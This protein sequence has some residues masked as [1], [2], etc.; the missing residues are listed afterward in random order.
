MVRFRTQ[1]VTS[2]A[3]LATRIAIAFATQSRINWHG[4][5]VAARDGVVT[6]QGEVPTVADRRLVVGLT[7]GVAGV[8]LIDD[9]INV[10]EIRGQANESSQESVP[11]QQVVSGVN[12]ESIRQHLSQLPLVTESLEDILAAHAKEASK[13]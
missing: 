3:D 11:S 2:D 7:R 12:A 1:N 13:D 5:H 10:A 6:L 8:R 4:I 9:K